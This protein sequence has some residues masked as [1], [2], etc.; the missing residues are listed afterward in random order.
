MKFG[1]FWSNKIILVALI[2]VFAFF[3]AT[4]CANQASKTEKIL[5]RAN[6]RF[7]ARQYKDAY[8]EINRALSLSS[9]NAFIPVSVLLLAEPIYFS[10]LQKI[11]EDKEYVALEDVEAN[12]FRYPQVESARINELIMSLVRTH[13]SSR[14]VQLAYS[15]RA[16]QAN[17]LERL[18]SGF[19]GE[20]ARQ[21]EQ[22]AFLL[23]L[24]IAVVV[25]V[26]TFLLVVILLALK[27]V[28]LSRE[29][30][31][32]A[33]TGGVVDVYTMAKKMSAPPRELTAECEKLGEKIDEA[34][35]RRNNSKNVAELVYKTAFALGIPSDLAAIFYCAALVYDAGFLSLPPELLAAEE[36]GDSEREMLRSHASKAAKYLSFVPKEYRGV[37]VDAAKS[38][39]ENID[40]SGYPEGLS[41]AE[42][43][44]IARLIR[45]CESYVSIASLRSWKEIRDKE[46]AIAELEK[47]ADFYDSK[48][49]ACLR[50]II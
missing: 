50:A 7:S 1:N 35:F 2:A 13:D 43:P 28:R 33:R 32:S 38:H 44:L 15:G 34:T 14:N 29:N 8:D 39:H 21:K 4:G 41:G 19:A 24:L 17:P 18:L 26:L 30:A 12:L 11:A 27:I 22:G 48:I 25:L 47:N 9:K 45:V 6:E 5:L 42:I 49:V 16:A 40:G 20:A 36:I 23:T 31:L 37:F 46:S 3:A 10:Y